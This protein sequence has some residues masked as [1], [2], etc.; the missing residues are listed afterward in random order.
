[1]VTWVSGR[2]AS[3]SEGIDEERLVGQVA[4]EAADV[5]A[6]DVLGA[7]GQQLLPDGRVAAMGVEGGGEQRH[8][9]FVGV[10]G[11][12]AAGSVLRGR[13]RFLPGAGRR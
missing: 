7:V 1:M 6:E 12:S 5:L 10:G 4:E 9:G 2:E 11:G 13:G 3:L 8:V